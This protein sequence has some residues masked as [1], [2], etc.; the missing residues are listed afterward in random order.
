MRVSDLFAAPDPEEMEAICSLCAADTDGK[1]EHLKRSYELAMG[2]IYKDMNQ[3]AS[4]AEGFRKNHDPES[5]ELQEAPV[6]TVCEPAKAL[7]SRRKRRAVYRAAA[8]AAALLVLLTASLVYA[9][10]LRDF[11][12][13][14]ESL[15]GMEGAMETLPGGY[16]KLDVSASSG[17]HRIRAYESLGDRNS[18]WIWLKTDIPWELPVD[19][20]TG[21]YYLFDTMSFSASDPS[22]TRGNPWLDGGGFMYCF[23]DQGCV[24]LMYCMGGYEGINRARIHVKLKDLYAYDYKDASYEERRLQTAGE[25]NLT[26]ENHYAANICTSH[27]VQPLPGNA[28][29]PEYGTVLL[30]GVELSPVSLRLTAVKNPL[31]W[32]N[33]TGFGELEAEALILKDGTEIS[34]KD[35]VQ[36]MVNGDSNFQVNTYLAFGETVLKQLPPPSEIS[37]LVVNGVHVNL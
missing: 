21:A 31:Q 25:W 29:D 8:A 11:D 27:P 26:W 6:R 2:K 13:R 33:S 22:E 17:G 37:A 24:G 34:L 20:E 32:R 36:N 5:Q 30:T 1:Q 10:G 23:N 4:D 15:L 35:G 18:Q 12:I 14:L 19:E 9:D 7:P 16:V 3:S 28:Q